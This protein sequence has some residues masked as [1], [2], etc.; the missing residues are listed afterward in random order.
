MHRDDPTSPRPR[1]TRP[2]LA[3]VGTVVLTGALAAALPASAAPPGGGPT[4]RA[5][6]Q[7]ARTAPAP[8][9]GQ[10]SATATPGRYIVVM[11]PR[12]TVQ[13]AG[14][15]RSRAVDRG[16]DVIHSYDSAVNGFAARLPASALTAVRSNPAVAYVEAD[17]RVSATADQANPTWGLDRLDQPKLPLDKNYHQDAT[18]T[19]VTAYVIDTGVRTSHQQ[20]TGRTAPGFSALDGGTDD[21]DGHGT[22][23]A[24]TIAGTTYGVAKKA[25]VVPVR[26]LDCDGSGYTSDVIAGLD[27]V[28]QDHAAGTPAVANMSLSGSAFKALDDAVARSIADGVVH[29]VAAGNDAAKDACGKSPA[30][31]PEAL[32]VGATT[33]TDARAAFS[34]IG[35][36]V[37]LFAPGQSILSAGIGSDTATATMSG[38]SMAAP[39]VA[40]VAALYLQTHPAATPAQVASAVTGNAAA[41][42]V[43]DAGAGS[44]NRLLQ[45]VWRRNLVGNPGFEAGKSGWGGT[46]TVVGNATP[47]ARSGSWRAKLNGTGKATTHTLTRSVAVPAG[48]APTLGF[49][50]KVSSAETATTARDKLVVEAVVGGKATALKTFSNLHKGSTYV[51]RTA[52]LKAYAG[53]TV[54]LRF[55]GVENASKQTT[56]L[57]DDVSA[58]VG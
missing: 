20:F 9:L 23:V 6:T 57:I 39:H 24:G 47:A 55:R 43:Q 40:G 2:L 44:P 8:L 45:G 18:G 21:C 10:A 42:V 14:A 3:A 48:S 28:N 41:N 38:T 34:N 25:T 46:S 58:W 37:D 1:I 54:T 30:R 13:R 17:Q 19:G 11:K 56:F 35:S 33:S 53:K 49:Y 31:L 52:A 50:L 15:V 26:V 36:C 32:T 7:R 27:W 22:H 16:A 29:A 12:A 4:D 5:G 51:Y